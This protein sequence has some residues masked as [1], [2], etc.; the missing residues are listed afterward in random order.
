MRRTGSWRT[1]TT[2][3]TCPTA[4]ACAPARTSSHRSRPEPVLLCID[5]GNTQTALGVYPETGHGDPEVRPTLIRDWRMRTDRRITADELE[6]A[7]RALLGPF[8]PQVTGI[9]ALSTVPAV[10][11]ELRV[12]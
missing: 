10:L 5:V 9:A 11:R 4:R 7:V 3:P 6:V 2:P 8:A 12:M 1:A